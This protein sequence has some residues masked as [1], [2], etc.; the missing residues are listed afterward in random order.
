MHLCWLLGYHEM[1]MNIDALSHGYHSWRSNRHADVISFISFA[2]RNFRPASISLGC[3]LL[4][5]RHLD[6]I[7]TMCPNVSCAFTLTKL[8]YFFWLL[9]LLR[10]VITPQKHSRMKKIFVV[11]HD[12]LKV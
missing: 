1:T 9:S 10:C 6:S 4:L 12:E 8:N 11:L 2:F 3:T 5:G 7:L